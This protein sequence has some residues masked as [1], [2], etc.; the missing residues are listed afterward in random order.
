M[1]CKRATSLEWNFIGD[2]FIS[3]EIQNPIHCSKCIPDGSQIVQLKKKR[4][5]KHKK[6]SKP[7]D[8]T[9]CLMMEM[10]FAKADLEEEKSG[11][12]NP[13]EKVNQQLPTY[14]NFFRFVFWTLTS[15]NFAILECWSHLFKISK[16]LHPL[17]TKMCS[18][19]KL[20]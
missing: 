17:T 1:P 19:P 11:K 15:A 9:S 18:D 16:C 7:D 2:D 3:S 10:P 6:K 13:K 4:R 14:P 5:K 8:S 20:L 12:Y